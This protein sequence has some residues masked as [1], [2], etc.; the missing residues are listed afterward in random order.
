[1]SVSTGPELGQLLYQLQEG[2]PKT[3]SE[4]QPQA[5][6]DILYALYTY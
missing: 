1:M 2:N 4:S 5:Q 3:S 6:E